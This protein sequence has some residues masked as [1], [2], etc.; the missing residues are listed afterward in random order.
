MNEFV[1]LRLRGRRL[2]V[3]ILLENLSCFSQSRMLNMNKRQSMFIIVKF[4]EI[5]FLVEIPVI[6]HIPLEF[7]VTI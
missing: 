3:F 7:D 6:V 4:K 1:R 5:T 2:T